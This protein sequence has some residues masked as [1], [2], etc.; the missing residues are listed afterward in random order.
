MRAAIV[1][2][3]RAP[4]VLEASELP[5]P[6]PGPGELS[7]DVTHAAVG[8]VDVVIRERLYKY[9]EG[10]PQLRFG[11]CPC[12]RTADQPENAVPGL[13]PRLA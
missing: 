12:L 7:I 11:A 10:L 13:L 4:D 6:I 3:F 2:R 5:D 1:T 9:R 8:L